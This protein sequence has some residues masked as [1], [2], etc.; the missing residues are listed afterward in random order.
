MSK[1]SWAK[2][3]SLYLFIILLVGCGKGPEGNPELRA[4][5]AA[6]QCSV[7]VAEAELMRARQALDIAHHNYQVVVNT[8]DST[9][10]EPE[11]APLKSEEDSLLIDVAR[12][13]LEIASRQVEICEQQLVIRLSK[14]FELTRALRAQEGER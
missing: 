9:G 3:S 10:K 6:A 14:L 12:I 5:V 4:E 8:P 7:E 13:E 1:G 2:R 11:L